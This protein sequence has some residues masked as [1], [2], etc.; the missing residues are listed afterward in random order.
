M[1]DAV[2]NNQFYDELGDRWYED[3]TH[4]IALLRAESKLKIDYV[5]EVFRR[6]KVE[7]GARLLD[8]G[9]GGGLI[10]NPL[11]K[12]GFE[13]FGIDQSASS[14]ATAK[15]RASPGSKVQY[16]E[17]NAY[18]LDFP[19]RSF[20]T[21]MLLDFLEHVD[22]PAR[23]V[24]EALRVLKPDGILLFYTFNRTFI[25]GI[26]AVKAVE[27]I[28]RDCP[29][30]F[31]L[32]RMFIKP[33]ELEGMLASSGFRVREYRGLRPKIGSRAFWVSLM[34]RRVHRD[35]GFV[36]TRDL[37]LGYMGFAKCN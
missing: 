9:C 8:I 10:S 16:A 28:A 32:L 14:L 1:T 20:D 12:L 36:Y 37:N 22:D 4:I 33:K 24:K 17:G 2:I 27:F 26:L 13:V 34:T 5:R 21:V 11:A 19:D 18:Q 23:A 6:E 7:A 35:F 30:N 29:K 25:A 3:D 15:R 31:H